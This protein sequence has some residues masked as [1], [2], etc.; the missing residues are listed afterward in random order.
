VLSRANS[1]WWSLGALAVSALIVL[2]VFTIA[3]LAIGSGPSI[4]P[5]LARTVLPVYVVQTLAL[6]AGVGIFTLIMGSGTAWLITMYRFPG[7]KVLQWALVLP[8]AIPTYIIAYTFVHVF[9]YAGPVQG[10][11]RQSF[12]WS[13]PGDYW[14][15]ELRS[16]PGAIGVL[17][18]VL[19]PYVY[20]TSRASFIKQRAAQIEVARTLGSSLPQAL[21]RIALPLARPAIAIGVSLA[22]MECLN[23]IGAVEFFGVRTLSVGIYATW[24]GKG[25]LAGAAQ[26]ALVMMLFVIGLIVLEQSGRRLE[27]TDT[28]ASKEAAPRGVQLHGIKG[29]LAMATCGL[30]AALGFVLP[31]GVLLSFAMERGGLI[32]ARIYGVAAMNSIMVSLS[33]ALVIL[34][35]G[36]FIAYAQK[37]GRSRTVVL[38]NRLIMA[39]YA[40]PGAVLAIGVLVPLAAFD[41]AL[42]SFMR[43]QFGVSSGL[44][45]T[46]SMAGLV[47]AYVVRFLAIGLGSLDAGLKRITPNLSAAA[48]TLGRGPLSTLIEIDLPL[49]RPALLSAALLVFVEAMKE[50]SAT[51]ILRPFNFE[52]LATLVYA[53][54]SLDQLEDTGLAALTIV[55]AGIVP[56]ILLSRIM[57]R[58]MI[59]RPAQF[60]SS[61]KLR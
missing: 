41:N 37:L 51:L 13:S 31:A 49:L 39:G 46:G 14:F 32:S 30:P 6:M 55:A 33:A 23:D 57:G 10:A 5:Q 25:N 9:E 45:L 44:L 2:P 59:P 28:G 12:S 21:R 4:W 11:L 38:A 3:W 53:Q 42:D 16:L 48:R 29:F 8:L 24:L 43:K 26:L 50:L 56:I 34:G 19:Y 60:V 35:L 54:A 40:T 20:L 47:M 18:L 17:S 58:G 1:F 7:R 22:M 61:A 36:L 52:T 27:R 15:P